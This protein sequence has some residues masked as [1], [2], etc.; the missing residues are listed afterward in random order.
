MFNKLVIEKFGFKVVISQKQNGFVSLVALVNAN[1]SLAIS[2]VGPQLKRGAPVT[3]KELLKELAVVKSESLSLIILG[4]TPF[5]LTANADVKDHN[6][7]TLTILTIL[8]IITTTTTTTIL[9]TL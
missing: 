8:T 7:S 6:Q 9:T 3:A 2:L 1:I 4:V 5:I